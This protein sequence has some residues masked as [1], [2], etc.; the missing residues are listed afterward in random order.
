MHRSEVHS[1]K[2]QVDETE[3]VLMDGQRL[4]HLTESG[5]SMSAAQKNIT[6]EDDARGPYHPDETDRLPLERITRFV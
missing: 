5:Y 1:Q 2:R 4:G 6:P 3:R